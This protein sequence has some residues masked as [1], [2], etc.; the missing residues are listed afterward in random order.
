MWD[1]RLESTTIPPLDNPAAF[2]AWK[3]EVMR[4]QNRLELAVKALESRGDLGA[5]RA[6]MLLISAAPDRARTYATQALG[7]DDIRIHLLAEAH[8]A[9]LQAHAAWAGQATPKFDA[10]SV[11]IVLERILAEAKSLRDHSTFGR[12]L[13]MRVHH[14][15]AD[16]YLINGAMEQVHKHAAELS[17]LAFTLDLPGT[18]LAANYYL[19]QVA[20]SDGQPVLAEDLFRS[21]AEDPNAGVLG[22]RAKRARARMLIQMGDEDSAESLLDP[23]EFTPGTA[24]F[25]HTR[26]LRFLTLRE[27]IA[28]DFT[29]GLNLIP[30]RTAALISVYAEIARAIG[31]EPGF[32]LSRM[33][34]WHKALDH[35]RRLE[36][37]A[38]SEHSGLEARILGAFILLQLGYAGQALH[39]LPPT[40]EWA[41][42]PAGT[43]AQAHFTLIEVLNRLLPESAEALLEALEHAACDLG[44]VEPRI[45]HQIARRQRL[46]GPQ[47]V[48]LLSIFPMLDGN[49]SGKHRSTDELKRLG[50]EAIM[51]VR[52]RP[53]EVYGRSSLR[54]TQAAWFTLE[55]FDVPSTSV[56]LYDGGGQRKA[57]YHGLFLPFYRQVYWHWPV[58]P[59]RLAFALLCC[60]RVRSSDLAIRRAV[61]ELR[62]SHGFISP[63]M[64]ESDVSG[65]LERIDDIL[66]QL[67]AERITPE[68]AHM[69]ILGERGT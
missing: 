39:R 7:G 43:R 53:I 56:E 58:A 65:T 50:R 31:C 4:D 69:A 16:A 29:H 42:L 22:P 23:D 30:N 40:E 32:D 24:Q 27:A 47:G 17:H 67:E 6:A 34:H 25:H 8:L 49:I 26:G 15:L 13:V 44:Q 60:A 63:Q 45:L 48:A 28:P 11:P 10:R 66:I 18:R 36:E 61:K 41:G 51:N 2:D 14:M 62:R 38:T 54:P 55:S 57:L 35:L 68:H 12:E 20:E 19:A 52:A 9:V 5:M 37:S 21:V 3:R 59:A 1:D 33:E 46:L 64:R